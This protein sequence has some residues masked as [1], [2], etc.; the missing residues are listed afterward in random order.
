[1]P[2]RRVLLTPEGNA[3]LPSTNIGDVLY[4]MLWLFVPSNGHNNDPRFFIAGPNSKQKMY[5]VILY[6][7]AVAASILMHHSAALWGKLVTP[8]VL[9]ILSVTP[10]CTAISVCML[11][12]DRYVQAHLFVRM[13][14]LQ[15]YY[16]S[17]LPG[18][19][20]ATFCSTVDLFTIVIPQRNKLL[21]HKDST[22][23]SVAPASEQSPAC[24]QLSSPNICH[25][26]NVIL[27]VILSAG[28]HV[29]I[30]ASLFVGSFLSV[31]RRA[32]ILKRGLDRIARVATAKLGLGHY[33]DVRSPCSD[34][35]REMNGSNLKKRLLQEATAKA[36]I[37]VSA[38]AQLK[39]ELGIITAPASLPP[40]WVLQ[41][42]CNATHLSPTS[43]C[44]V[45]SESD[46]ELRRQICR[47]SQFSGPTDPYSNLIMQLL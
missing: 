46:F 10:A 4:C 33:S 11:G 3:H 38:I 1:M 22:E 37:S 5:T 35:K 36:H 12:S 17:R 47:M 41:T 26:I 32:I 44:A 7:G 8:V 27:I 14:F 29:L 9:C 43:S 21:P 30:V 18:L 39:F 34:I 2:A 16:D 13:A 40:R 20:T 23:V 31:K 24:E 42:P 45:K 28:V 6:L 15:P 19:K 25:A